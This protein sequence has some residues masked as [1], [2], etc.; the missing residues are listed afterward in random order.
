MV[1][2]IIENDSLEAELLS[3]FIFN[4]NP[5]IPKA[6][7]G[8]R[9]KQPNG[10]F[11]IIYKIPVGETQ[12]KYKEIPFTVTRTQY[13]QAQGMSY[14]VGFYEELL[15]EN[16]QSNY[17]LITELLKDAKKFNDKKDSK[18][19]VCHFFKGGNWHKYNEIPRRKKESLFLPGTILDDLETDVKMFLENKQ[20][21]LE[22]GVPFKRNYLFSGSPGTGKTSTICCIA[23]LLEMDLATL[24]IGPDTSDNDFIKAVNNI[25]NKTIFVIEDIDSLFCK[26]P[27]ES[28][29]NRITF[30]SLT[31]CLDGILKK[32]G[33]ITFMTTNYPENLD[34]VLLRDGRIDYFVDFKDRSEE[35][36][37]RMV[38]KY[39]NGKS[40]QAEIDSFIDKILIQKFSMSSLQKFCFENRNKKLESKMSRDFI[41]QLNN[42]EF[43]GNYDYFS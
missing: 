6:V 29:T 34:K 26:K 17:D 10:E 27:T 21:Y 31:N 43:K 2:L 36:V 28:S 30:S 13:G 9:Q 20:D 19:V 42:N 24:S 8:K 40:N 7:F 25:P 1:K 15:L 35:Q 11:Q 12:F 22:Y 5:K 23:S 4:L 41:A 39:F 38:D 3:R 14:S 16:S 37:K 18:E 32:D 33:L